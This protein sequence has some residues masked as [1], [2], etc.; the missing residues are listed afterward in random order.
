MEADE[1]VAL[2][3]EKRNKFR[4]LLDYSQGRLDD[5]IAA[6][7]ALDDTPAARRARLLRM[8]PNIRSRRRRKR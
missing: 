3:L 5:A 1:D 8:Y 7:R 4:E 2:W 6:R